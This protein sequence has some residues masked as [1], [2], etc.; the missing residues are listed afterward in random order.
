MT[1]LDRVLVAAVVSS[2][3][4]RHADI[5]VPEHDGFRALVRASADDLLTRQRIVDCIAET[6]APLIAD[7]LAVEQAAGAAA[8]RLLKAE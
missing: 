5:L 3:R 7:D 1:D 8:D 6:F 4:T 2:V